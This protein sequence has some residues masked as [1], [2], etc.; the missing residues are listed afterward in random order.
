MRQLGL[1]AAK[2]HK[3]Y[4]K[5]YTHSFILMNDSG[6]AFG[7]L[8]IADTI[9]CREAIDGKMKFIACCS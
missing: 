3:Y 8:V 4:F 1:I 6:I 7:Q 5:R 9:V 2:F